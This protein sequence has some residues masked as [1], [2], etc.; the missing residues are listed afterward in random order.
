MPPSMQFTLL[1]SYL[2]SSC[3]PR[4]RPMNMKFRSLCVSCQGGQ[5]NF[6]LLKS[7]VTNVQVK[8]RSSEVNGIWQW[9][10]LPLAQFLCVTCMFVSWTAV[11]KVTQV[12]LQVLQTFLLHFSPV[13]LRQ[14]KVE[15]DLQCASEWR[16]ECVGFCAP[17]L[18][19]FVSS[20]SVHWKPALQWLAQQLNERNVFCHHAAVSQVGWIHFVVIQSAN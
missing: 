11:K 3:M 4:P 19:A 13:F 14:V 6:P 15:R 8:D 9:K 5:Q 18:T 1:R 20:L 2:F 17:R 10:T 12:A 16:S 7:G